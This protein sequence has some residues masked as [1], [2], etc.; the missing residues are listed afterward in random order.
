M[1]TCVCIQSWPKK[2]KINISWIHIDKLKCLC[3]MT[4][5]KSKSWDSII[6]LIWKAGSL[7]L[8]A[9]CM[10]NV[11]TTVCT[12]SYCVVPQLS[13]SNG[14][15]CIINEDV[16]AHWPTGL[17]VLGLLS[18]QERR[19]RNGQLWCVTGGN[20]TPRLPVGDIFLL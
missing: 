20:L 1:S 13:G 15:P 19:G 18:Q 5:H 4:S 7:V 12:M 8:T 14:R 2:R 9:S 17:E 16:S 10:V 3:D 6:S 11:W